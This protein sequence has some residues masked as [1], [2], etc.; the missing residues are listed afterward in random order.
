MLERLYGT[1]EQQAALD[2][3][4][5]LEDIE[6]QDA[7]RRLDRIHRA[8]VRHR[9]K[10]GFVRAARLPPVDYLVRDPPFVVE[11]D[12]RQH[13]TA[14]R[15]KA[16]EAYGD[17][18]S[19]G[20]DR[21]RWRSMCR[22]IDA[23]D[24][25]PAD[26]DE[27]RAW[28]DSL[29]DHPPLLKPGFGPTVRIRASDFAWCS[30]DPERP[31]HQALFR[32]RVGLS[33]A[34]AVTVRPPATS[35]PFWSRIV[36]QGPWAG[37]P[38][39]VRRLLDRVC[40]VWPSGIRS[41]ILVTCGGFLAFPWPEALT[42]SN[43]GDVLDPTPESVREVFRAA[44]RAVERLLDRRLRRRL[45]ACTDAITLGVDSFKTKVP[46]AGASICD[47]H[48]ELVYMIDLRDGSIH[49]TGKSYPTP[50]QA[51][52]L[53]RVADLE[54]HF[55]TFDNMPALLLGCHDLNMFNPR[56][57]AVAGG[58]RLE[59]INRMRRLVRKNAP[60]IVVHHPHT[61]DTPRI[62]SL[63]KGRLEKLAPSVDVFASAGR[64]YDAECVQ[65]APLDEVL[66]AMVTG[67]SLDF[68][69][70]VGA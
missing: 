6:A 52:G 39:D 70:G 11:F 33:P 28:Y 44:D 26:R 7:R 42:R 56:G 29:R 50:G 47:L 35:A 1:V 3:P 38:R 40:A 62:W 51:H 32:E 30:L 21:S 58:W 14:P 69:L 60:R 53:L 68:V 16:L 31:E 19:L 63:A 12:E 9:G 43:V 18:L 49:R 15:G 46:T 65:R 10:R 13:F 17:D 4:A 66:S 45:L 57:N 25:D 54:S 5:R 59:V 36:I 8:L 24:D 48:A 55:T 22:E 61:T 37:D 2:V 23:H 67:T 41:R 64:Y 27:Q 20:F 34:T